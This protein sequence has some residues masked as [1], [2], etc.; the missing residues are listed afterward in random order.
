MSRNQ[1][2]SEAINI[3]IG[4]EWLF[5]CFHQQDF[6]KHQ[7]VQFH[8]WLFTKLWQTKLNLNQK[9]MT[10]KIKS[11]KSKQY[12]PKKDGSKK[13]QKYIPDL[14]YKI[15]ELLAKSLY[16]TYKGKRA[17]LNPSKI[18]Q[19]CKFPMEKKIIIFCTLLRKSILITILMSLSLQ[20]YILLKIRINSMIML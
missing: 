1:S 10:G 7:C 5:C 2:A 11:N 3:K 9:N 6:M 8:R 16:E 17:L 14:M 13:K 19:N 12:S 18:Y 15:D 20:I 4:S